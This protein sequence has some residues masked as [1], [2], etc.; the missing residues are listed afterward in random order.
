[1]WSGIA[2]SARCTTTTTVNMDC[3][4]CEIAARRAPAAIVFED[5]LTLAFVD[6]RQFNA[7]H[8]LVIPRAHLHDVRELD[9]TTGSALMLTVSRIARAVGNAF[10][11]QGMSLWSSIGEAAF[12]EVPHLHVHVH[13]RLLNDDMLRVYPAEPHNTNADVLTQYAERVRD[14][15]RNDGAPRTRTGPG[16]SFERP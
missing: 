14:Q 12:Q 7:G 10:P 13:P 15:L 5:A 2:F 3:I 1:M 6:L 9:E 16:P 4:F 11:N 8:I